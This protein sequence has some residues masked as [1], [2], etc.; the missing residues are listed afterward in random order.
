V[1]PL[2]WNEAG[3]GGKGRVTSAAQLGAAPCSRVRAQGAQSSG[4]PCRSR[5]GARRRCLDCPTVRCRGLGCAH[6]DSRSDSRPDV[7]AST[8]DGRPW[9]AA[10]T[11]EENI[12]RESLRIFMRTP[13]PPATNRRAIQ[14]PAAVRHPRAARRARTMSSLRTYPRSKA[15]APSWAAEVSGPL[16]QAP[17]SFQGRGFTLDLE[18]T[19]FQPPGPGKWPSRPPPG[20][21][22]SLCERQQR[23]DPP[24]IG[25]CPRPA[26]P[27]LGNL[28]RP[29]TPRPDRRRALA[30][31][32]Q[33]GL[34]FRFR[35]QELEPS[36]WT[37][38]TM[39][40]GAA[41]AACP[42][43]VPQPAQVAGFLKFAVSHDQELV[44]VAR[45]ASSRSGSVVTTTRRAAARAAPAPRAALSR[46]GS[47]AMAPHGCGGNVV[48]LHA[49][50]HFSRSGPTT[51]RAAC[52]TQVLEP[53]AAVHRRRGA[54]MAGV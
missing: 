29:E 22:S 32:L 40:A 25:V 26:P 11:F 7:P 31:R 48:A 28:R 36:G 8:S 54:P 30:Q 9:A 21:H 39:C 42:T 3:A 17:A 43:A 33:Q 49:C 13:Q 12:S 53:P 18:P 5:M 24:S 27:P 2:R 37:L 44:Q 20:L 10:F 50:S 19:R 4:L 41:R 23:V 6:E 38:P 51:R 47:P 14:A 1:K 35:E 15:P 52:R 34:R 16:R 46:S 45:S